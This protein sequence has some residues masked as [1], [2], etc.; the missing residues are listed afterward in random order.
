MGFTVKSNTKVAVKKETTEGTYAAPAAEDF[1]TALEDGLEVNG[2]KESLE[3]NILGTGLTKAQSRTA[4][5]SVSGTIPC[6]FKAG[7]TDGSAPEYSVLVEA[8][9]GDIRNN[10]SSIT[11]GTGHSTT[12]LNI[13]DVDISKLKVGDSII[14][15]ES[16][17]HHIS[18]IT[19]VDETLGAANITLLTA[20]TSAFSDNVE[21]AAHT[22]YFTADKDHPTFSVTKYIEDAVEKRGTGCRV[23]SMAIENFV[24]NQLATLNFGF[25]GLDF[26]DSL[27][28]PG[29]TP[30]FDSS[31][32]PI[33]VSACLFKNGTQLTV[34]ELSLSVE[35]TVA[36]ITSTCQASGKIG[37]RISERTITGSLTP[38]IED[39]NIDIQTNFDN[40]DL[41][42]L[43]FYAYNPT[44]TAGEFNQAIAVYL[45]NCSITELGE[46]DSDGIM[47]FSLS[48]EASGGTDGSDTQ[49]FMTY[50]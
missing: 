36:L 40:D 12:V 27:N 1:I 28:A 11:T 42:S 26:S 4:N 17:A 29:V 16:G 35:N 46:T 10:S 18:V 44:A 5:R 19:A 23:N 34:A 32:P 38:Y 20:G 30:T 37:S 47:Q 33:I 2:S 13:E 41:F 7:S 8:A 48:F 15:K 45:P 31:L 3:R 6:E 22:T 50:I 43:F 21:I 49:M 9:L 39:N 25:E 24:P 14:I